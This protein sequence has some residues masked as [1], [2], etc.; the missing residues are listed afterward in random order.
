[1]LESYEVGQTITRDDIA[2]D[3]YMPVGEWCAAVVDYIGD[4]SVELVYIDNDG[5]ESERI[6]LTKGQ[7]DEML[8]WNIE[9][10]VPDERVH[11][12]PVDEGAGADET[13]R[14][15]RMAHLLK[16]EEN[17]GSRELLCGRNAFRDG[18]GRVHVFSDRRSCEEAFRGCPVRI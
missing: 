14:I 3:W 16:V 4:N 15:A 18:F 17:R 10:G 11:D 2:S 9:K 7:M 8:G 12:E 13:D 1:M 5:Q 6:V